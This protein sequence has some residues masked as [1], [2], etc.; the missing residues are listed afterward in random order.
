VERRGL[1]TGQTESG[2]DRQQVVGFAWLDL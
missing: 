2:L 1:L